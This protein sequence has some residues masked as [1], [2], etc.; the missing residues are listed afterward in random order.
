MG[1]GSATWFFTAARLVHSLLIFFYFIFSCDIEFKF[2]IKYFNLIMILHVVWIIGSTYRKGEILKQKWHVNSQFFTV[3]R[4]TH[5]SVMYGI[6][7]CNRSFSGGDISAFFAEIFFF[8]FHLWYWIQLFTTKYSNLILICR[9]LVWIFGSTYRKGQ[10]LEQLQNTPT[11]Q[12]AGVFA[13]QRYVL[14]FNFLF[15][16]DNKNKDF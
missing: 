4:D 11:P 2:T 13:C 15:S 10:I 9:I 7:Q 14:L 8:K 12:A 6:R 3:T 5:W 16:A 1:S